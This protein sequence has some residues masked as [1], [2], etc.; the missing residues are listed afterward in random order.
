MAASPAPKTRGRP[1]SLNQ[2][3]I[4]DAAFRVS[5]RSGA[6]ALTFQAIGEELNVHPTAIYRHFHDKDG[7]ILALIDTLHGQVLEELPDPS[8][9]WAADLAELA[10]LTWIVFQR[11]PEIAQFA[12]A[13]T[14]RRQNEFD[15]IERILDCMRRAGFTDQDAARYYRS[16]GDFVLSFSSQDAALAALEPAARDADLQAW[17]ILYPTLP[18]ARYPNIS[19]VLSVI[20]PVGD[21]DNFATALSLMLDALRARA[22]SARA[23]LEPGPQRQHRPDNARTSRSH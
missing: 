3:L 23:R 4:I 7:L 11:H 1:P 9:D 5:H 18:A 12:A 20:P 14:T 19:A 15:V 17:Q 21:P 16:F 6:N 8:D 13:R 10:R 22:K 2:A